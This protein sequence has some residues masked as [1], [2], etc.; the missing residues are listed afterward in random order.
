MASV[1][2]TL[3][4]LA[5]PVGMGLMMFMMRGQNEGSAEQS[6]GAANSSELQALRAEIEALKARGAAWAPQNPLP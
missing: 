2:Y 6:S 5:C 3:A 1:F 4:V